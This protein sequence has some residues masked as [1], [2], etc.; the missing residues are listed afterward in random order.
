MHRKKLALR[1]SIIT[2]FMQLVIAFL[3]FISRKITLKYLGVD[4]LGLNSTLTEILSM[5]SLTDLGFA[6]AVMYRLYLPLANNDRDRIS[7]IVLF[8]KK[9]YVLV[10][11]LITILG[12][13]LS[14]FLQFI[15]TKV[16][17]NMSIVY[18]AFYLLLIS[19]VSTY[20]LAYGRTLLNADRQI[21]VVSIIDTLFNVIFSVLRIILLVRYKM[22]LLFVSM[23]ILQTVSSNIAVYIYCKRKYPWINRKQ[24]VDQETSKGIFADTRDIFIGKTTGYIFNSTDNIIISAVIGTGY[25]GLLG[26]YKTITNLILSLITSIVAPIKPMLGNY[27]TTM[28]EIQTKILISRYDFVR[29]T[30]ANILLVPTFCLADHFIQW[31]YG[32]DYSLGIL[33]VLLIVLIDYSSIMQGTVGECIDIAGLFKKINRVYIIAA[34]VNLIIS[35]V[36]AFLWGVNAV[37]M[38]TLIGNMIQWYGRALV[39]YSYCFENVKGLEKYWRQQFQY[40]IT[41]IFYIIS[42]M[43]I[44][45]M[46]TSEK[47]LIMFLCKGVIC[48]LIGCVEY[49]LIYKKRDEYIY[50]KSL[51]YKEDK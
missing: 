21:H 41:F 8:L 6:G 40:F 37:L 3:A 23:T 47:T 30:I 24:K 13:I 34:V 48:V 45:S 11:T 1:S 16:D 29:F 51:F 9:I 5:L 33:P 36:G 28:S 2:F 49:W 25:V 44:F 38:G 42:V 46:L 22:Y 27:I 20:F 17:I 12:L 18:I 15:I 14:L 39:A 50:M 7:Q 19:T 32:S 31:W 43:I 4:Y 26:N 35:I 10:G